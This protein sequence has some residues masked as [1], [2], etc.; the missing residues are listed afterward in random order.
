MNARAQQALHRLLAGDDSGAVSLQ[1]DEVVL[2]VSEVIDQVKQRL[3]DRGLTF[4][5]NAPIPETD[6]QIVL[7]E[8]PELRQLRTIYA[9]GNPVAQVAARPSS[10]CSTS[11]R[12]SSP[13]ASHG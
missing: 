7:L 11:R 1:G 2:D 4:L 8:A 5:E 12:S 10:G 9:F 3:V 13:C 6:R